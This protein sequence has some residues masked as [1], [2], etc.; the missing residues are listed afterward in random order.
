[1]NGILNRDPSELRAEFRKTFS[2]AEPASR[3]TSRQEVVTR[4]RAMEDDIRDFV[5]AGHSVTAIAKYFAPEGTR[6]T[7]ETVRR[8][9]IAEFGFSRRKRAKRG[10]KKAP[11]TREQSGDTIDAKS[12][13][14]S[15]DARHQT[16]TEDNVTSDASAAIAKQNTARSL[17]RKVDAK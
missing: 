12:E 8:T 7:W 9:M 17:F 6:P 4:L 3:A 13:R 11:N 1:M 5:A 16:R 15:D 10:A 2:S 14:S